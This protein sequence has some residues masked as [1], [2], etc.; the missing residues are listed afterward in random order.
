[1]R[2]GSP[3][4]RPSVPATPTSSFWPGWTTGGPAFPTRAFRTVDVGADEGEIVAGMPGS[5]LGLETGQT[6]WELTDNFGMAAGNH[7]LTFGT[8]GELIDLVD[9]VLD[10]PAGFWFFDSLDSL[11]RG[12]ASCYSRDLATAGSQVAFRVNQIGVYLQ[13]QWV[14]TPRL[15][16]DGRSP[17]RRA[18]PPH[19]AHAESS[20]PS[21]EL[22]INTALTPSG[23]PLW[24]P[25]L[26]VNYDLSGRGTTVLRGGVGLFA[27]RP[28]YQWFRNVYARTGAGRSRSNARA[29]TCR[30]SR[31]IRRT[32]PQRV[33]SRPLQSA[34]INYFDP[35]FRFP[36]NLK[37]ALGADLLLPGGVVGTVDLLYT[38]GVNTFHVVDVNL[39]GPLGV[40]A[41]EGG[42]ADVRHHR[43]G[44][45]RGDTT[46]RTPTALDAVFEIR[47]GS[48][49]RAFSATAQLE[50]RFANGTEL[51]AAYTYTDAKDRMSPDED[52]ARPQRRLH[53]AERHAGA[54]RDLRTSLWERPHKVTLVGTT[55]LPLGFRLGLIYIGMSERAVHLRGGGGCQRG[56]ILAGLRPVERC[57]VRAERRGRH[58]PG[59]P[60]GVRGARPPHPGRALP[61][62]PAGPSAGA[63]Q[64]PRPLGARDPGAAVEAVSS[65]GQARTRGHRRPLQRA[66]LPGRRLGP[67][68][69]DL[70]RGTLGN[71]V[72]AAGAGRLRRSQRPRRVRVGPGLPAAR[73]TWRPRAGASSS[74]PRCP[75]SGRSVVRLEQRLERRIAPERREQQVG[76]KGVRGAEAEHAPSARLPEQGDGL[77]PPAEAGGDVS[78][79]KDLRHLGP[80]GSSRGGRS[81]R[82]ECCRSSRPGRCRPAAP[83]SGPPPPASRA[84]QHRSG[85]SARARPA[86]AP[87]DRAAGSPR[88]CS[89]RGSSRCPARARAAP[90]CSRQRPSPSEDAREPQARLPSSS[91]CSA[92]E[93]TE[94]PADAPRELHHLSLPAESGERT[95]ADRLPLPAAESRQRSVMSS[96]ARYSPSM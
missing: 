61:P 32:S 4:P 10:H 77:F 17:P 48:G 3:G 84:C 86:R 50:K 9:D 7:R 36:Q 70:P 43:L 47:N 59:R 20:W 49:D 80:T 85:R 15:D 12:E 94:A 19:A 93:S 26:G 72:S 71:A 55:D 87:S 81:A 25:R 53:A 67:G 31:S 96:S 68:P 38:R 91:W 75:S 18:V 13:D 60:G 52:R 63:E 1:M 16:L 8:H 79:G 89:M 92:T 78:P 76:V 42:R 45:R 95:P 83:R 74:A 14:P 11:A 30:P 35:E 6:I 66:E 22:G 34:R 51:S 46:R 33:P 40:A 5:C 2:P 73:S 58:H 64:L 57:R 54:P 29:M 44:D 23:N 69:P 65:R 90:G 24:S 27:G 37:L 21:S 28:A 62:S 39:D 88:R 41:G 56:W 82:P